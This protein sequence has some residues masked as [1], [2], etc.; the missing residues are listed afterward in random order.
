M[1]MAGVIGLITTAMKALLQ[2]EPSLKAVS[3][4]WA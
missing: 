4:Y 3:Q 2:G 1:I